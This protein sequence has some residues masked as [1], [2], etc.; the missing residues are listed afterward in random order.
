[1]E[2]NKIVVITGA[3]SGIGLAAAKVFIQ[4][5]MKV[6]NLSRTPSPLKDIVS[7]H[8]DVG[9]ELSVGQAFLELEEKESEIDFLILNAGYGISGAVEE[10]KIEDAIQQFN[11]N[12]FGVVRCAKL[13]VPFLRK[14]QKGKIMIISSLAA[15]FPIPFQSFYAASKAALANFSRALA[16]EIAPFRIKVIT[17]LPGDIKTNFT[18]KRQKNIDGSLYNKRSNK[19][20]KVM[21]KDEVN[22]MS[23]EIIGKAIYKIS[24]KN[25]PKKQYTIGF[26]YKVLLLLAKILPIGIVDKIIRKIYS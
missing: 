19:A 6:Y 25:H 10:T 9:D 7:I 18:A 23:P 22:G 2:S 15:V 21:E 1:M 14:A 13:A 26:K 16:M 12:F 20:I 8:C 24:R 3:S 5:G 11:I 4:K 17:I